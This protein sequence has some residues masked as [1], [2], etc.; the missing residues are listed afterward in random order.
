MKFKKA[1]LL[2][3]AEQK[4]EHALARD[5]KHV[6]ASMCTCQIY[7]CLCVI[8]FIVCA[9]SAIAISSAS[10]KEDRLTTGE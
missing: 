6:P 5:K 10:L 8:E 1:G 9:K 4:F 7:V 2:D 3:E